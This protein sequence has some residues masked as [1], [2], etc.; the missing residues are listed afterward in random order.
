VASQG[1]PALHSDKLWA[2][3]GWDIRRYFLPALNGRVLAQLFGG[4][5]LLRSV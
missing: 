1:D 3:L 5:R 2:F 4:R